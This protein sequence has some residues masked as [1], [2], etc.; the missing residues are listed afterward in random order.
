MP[1]VYTKTNATILF[2]YQE[3]GLTIGALARSDHHRSVQWFQPLVDDVLN[4]CT[5][6]LMELGPEWDPHLK[7]ILCNFWVTQLPWSKS[8]HHQVLM[9]QVP[10]LMLLFL[11]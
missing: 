8:K 5:D 9:E 3:S 7:G 11:S 1:K 2:L 4:C 10:Q 6:S